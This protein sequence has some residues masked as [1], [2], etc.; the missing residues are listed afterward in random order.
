MPKTLSEETERLKRHWEREAPTYD[1]RMG[2]FE[3]VLV[4]GRSGVGVLASFRRGA[5]GGCGDGA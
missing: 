2:F 5:G 3:R 1:R 4:R